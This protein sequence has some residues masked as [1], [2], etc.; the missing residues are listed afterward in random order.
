MTVD[1]FDTVGI[2]SPAGELRAEFVPAANMLCHTL[3]HRDVERLDP[4]HGVR[5]YAE[6]GKTMGIPLLYPWANRLAEPAY[7][8]AGREVR[9]PGPD[10]R[11]PVDPNGL[12]IHGALPGLLRWETEASGGGDRLRARL[13]W[14]GPELTPLFPF[15]H[16]VEYEARAEDDRLHVTL[17]VRATGGGPVPVSFGFHP[18]LTL[19][20][21]PREEWEIGLGATERLLLDGHSIPTGAREPLEPRRFR[22]ADQDWDDALAGL[23]DPP[24]FS[25]AAEGRGVTV[26]FGEG[27]RFAQ[28]YTPAGRQF[29]CFEPMVAPTNALRDGT[30]LTVVEPGGEHRA[31]FVIALTDN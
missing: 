18:Y 22:L 10:G 26:T 21:V 5:A 1:G 19:P 12:P 29:I 4:G 23:A 13:A 9:L 24:A 6:R 25:A 30:A 2:V 3:T 17:T 7:R 14:D 16:E 28:V 15:E 27:Y 8:A 20:G 31:A 11:Y